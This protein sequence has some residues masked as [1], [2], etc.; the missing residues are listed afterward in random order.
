GWQCQTPSKT[1]SK[2][3]RSNDRSASSHSLVSSLR[4]SLPR[5]A[6]AVGV[7]E[8]IRTSLC[9]EDLGG[10]NKKPPA[11]KPSLRVNSNR[12]ASMSSRAVRPTRTRTGLGD[13]R[14]SGV[15]SGGFDATGSARL[16][17]TAPEGANHR[18]SEPIP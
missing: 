6:S 11:S 7:A 14:S 12:S 10:P 16:V 13:D 8:G 9:Q 15:S 3:A 4:L 18:D 17:S 5:I 2:P 1:S